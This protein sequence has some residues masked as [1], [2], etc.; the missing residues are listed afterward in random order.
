[1]FKFFNSCRSVSH[2][3]VVY[4]YAAKD[5]TLSLLFI[6]LIL[7]GILILRTANCMFTCIS[8]LNTFFDTQK[9]TL[10]LRQKGLLKITTRGWSPAFLAKVIAGPLCPI[11]S[12]ALPEALVSVAGNL[13][14]A[15]F[16]NL[17]L[18]F[19]KTTWAPGTLAF[20]PRF[21]EL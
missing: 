12:G 9:E 20:A 7:P 15:D 18:R 1:M 4:L 21:T 11:Y 19:S 6:L 2:I 10:L 8:K 16:E 17:V 13:V 5:F 14:R 3:F